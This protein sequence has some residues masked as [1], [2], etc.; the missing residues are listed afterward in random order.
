MVFN[1]VPGDFLELI[2]V[3]DG[4]VDVVDFVLSGVDDAADQEQLIGRVVF[5]DEGESAI[6][7]DHFLARGLSEVEAGDFVETV[8]F[9][10]LSHF[11]VTGAFVL[12]VFQG[13]GGGGDTIF[14]DL[15]DRLVDEFVQMQFGSLTARQQFV[16]EFGVQEGVATER[17][18]CLVEFGVQELVATERSLVLIEDV[19]LF[20]L[21]DAGDT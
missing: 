7:L 17:G 3:V 14:G 12:S 8:P 19:F 9:R 6:A 20:V 11:T 2:D 4:L 13:S 21:G 1:D 10:A 18:Q 5:D 15:Q 16:V